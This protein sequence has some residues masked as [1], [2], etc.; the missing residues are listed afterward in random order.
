[1][2]ITQNKKLFNQIEAAINYL[3]MTIELIAKR[4]KEELINEKGTF[5]KIYIHKELIQIEHIR[6]Q[7][8]K[9]TKK[10][11][12]LSNG[13]FIEKI[14]LTKFIVFNENELKAKKFLQEIQK[15]IKTYNNEKIWKEYEE[16]L[17]ILKE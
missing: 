3:I 15:L 8:S 17:K 14:K 6:N 13:Q 16:I 7:T 5:E 2:K 12:D 4:T 9:L 11:N 10:I 1:M